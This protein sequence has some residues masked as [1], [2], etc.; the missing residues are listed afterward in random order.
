MKNYSIDI[1]YSND[2]LI[3]YLIDIINEF[4][5]SKN[6][7]MSLVFNKTSY[8]SADVIYTEFNELDLKY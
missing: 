7:G 4:R 6:L 5:K 3:L 1:Q 8:S 2:V